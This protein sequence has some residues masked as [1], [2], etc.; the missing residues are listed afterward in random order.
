MSEA[1]MTRKDYNPGWIQFYG[2]MLNCPR[3]GNDHPRLLYRRFRR[4]SRIDHGPHRWAIHT[5]H[6]T[7]PDTGES[8]HLVRRYTR[9][10]R[11]TEFTMNSGSG[12]TNTWMFG[13]EFAA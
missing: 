2:D 7:C 12:G 9:S 1:E 3:C 5:H 8:I 6:A 10:W 11:T 4:Q 13:L